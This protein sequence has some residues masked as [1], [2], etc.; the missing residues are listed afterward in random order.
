MLAQLL[1][2]A[3]QGGIA[4]T[5]LSTFQNINHRVQSK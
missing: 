5:Y 3:E 1:K 2:P 4:S